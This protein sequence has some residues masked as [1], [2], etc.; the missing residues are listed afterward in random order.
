MSDS[1]NRP[2]ILLIL[3]DQQRADTIAALGNDHIRTPHL[4]R[5]ASEGTAFTSAYSPSPVCVPARSCLH[6]GQYPGKTGC[7]GN[8]HPTTTDDRDSFVDILSRGGYETM[9]IGKCHFVPDRQ[10]RRG[11]KRRLTQE[12]SPRRIEDDDYLQFLQDSPYKE[13]RD[14]HGTWR[15]MIYMPQT[16]PLD[17]AHHPT[18]WVG[19]RCIDFIQEQA[20]GGKPWFAFC[21]F[22]HP[23]PPYAPPAPWDM[24]Y[25]PDD[26][27]G[28]YLPEDLVQRQPAFLRAGL[29]EYYFDPPVSDTLWRMVKARYYAC[30]SFVDHQV[31]RIR[32][33]LEENGQL[34]N[35]LILFSSDHGE[36]LGDLGLIG[37]GNMY[38]AAARV[39]LLMRWGDGRHSGQRVDTPVTLVDIGPTILRAAGLEPPVDFDGVNLAEVAVMP[40]RFDGRIVFS[41]VFN[42]DRA[43]YLST[44]GR[45]KYI[46]SAADGTEQLFDLK[47]DPREDLNLAT[48]PAHEGNLQRLRDALFD[49]LESTGQHAVLESG[50]RRWRVWPKEDIRKPR[51]KSNDPCQWWVARGN[52]KSN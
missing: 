38:E 22:I 18:Q 16:S 11:F 49:Y 25:R 24:L 23:H 5:L 34:E 26:L 50:P 27:P 40:E 30:V 44:D 47:E 12:E 41:Q 35:T 46:H 4:D 43:L 9:G 21:S 42:P 1:S 51:T 52:A 36:M 6:Y 3:T 45:F 48:N 19:D 33:A 20:G 28:P 37:K 10:A 2:N 39:P 14:V 17:E 7:L 29:H 15:E 8:I 31:G 32:A 13:V